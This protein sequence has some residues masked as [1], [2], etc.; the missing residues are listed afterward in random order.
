MRI[1]QVSVGSVRMP[2]KEGS[3]PLQVIFNTSKHLA[4]MGHQ[5]VI[6]DRKYSKRDQAVEKIEGVEIARVNVIRLPSSKAPGFLR[7]T[8]AELNAILF[9]LAVSRYLGKNSSNIDIIHLHLTSIGLIVSI[10]NRRLRGKMFYTCHLS[11]W[12]LSADKLG[13]S[14]RVHLLLD[15]YLMRR[16]R[17]VIALNDTARKSFTHI[18]KVKADNIV[19]VPNGVDTDFFSPRLD[20]KE[21]ARERYG[22]EGRL[23]VLFVG[24]LAKIKGVEH[25]VKAA[26]AIVN[27]FGHKDTLFVL[28]G[29]HTYAGVD[30]PVNMEEMLT[31]IKQHQLDKNIILTGPL[32]LEEV[33]ALYA[34]CDIFVLPSLAEGD[35][36]VTLEAMASG[37]PVIGT[38]VGGIPNQIRDGWNGFLVDAGNEQQLADKIAYLIDNPNDRRRM[39][40]NSRKYA[41]DEF[42][43]GMVAEKLS[44]FYQGGQGKQD[45]C[46][47]T[48]G[49]QDGDQET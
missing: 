23:T 15:S 2:P 48:T 45:G 4:R 21:T 1:V 28:V 30:E 49:N 32:P 5:V 47:T 19:V 9:A 18:G 42:D 40:E 13:I 8:L 38:K 31:Y 37:K 14:G 46:S 3:A 12:A 17:R 11:Q 24:R 29:S 26:D 35:P 6:L 34:A 41:E 25:L 20:A 43:W 22:L 44:V 33:R 27:R 39:G 10:L 16:V 7:F 36:L